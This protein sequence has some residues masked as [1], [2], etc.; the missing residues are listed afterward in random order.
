[1]NGFYAPA[2][3]AIYVDAQFNRPGEGFT[4]WRLA[5]R[6]AIL[7]INPS[8]GFSTPTVNWVRE[9][10]VREEGACESLPEVRP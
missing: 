7:S 5:S 2:N 3:T 9:D 10:F 8:A 6:P 1:D 4:W